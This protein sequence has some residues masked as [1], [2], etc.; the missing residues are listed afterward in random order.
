M[1]GQRKATQTDE[2]ARQMTGRLH[3]LPPTLTIHEAGEMLGISRRSAYRAAARGEIPTLR[4]GR[5]VLVPTPRLLALLGLMVDGALD[6][7]PPLAMA[8][9]AAPGSSGLAARIEDPSGRARE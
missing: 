3:E 9:A 5:R 8:A 7:Q 1:A 6:E 4:L 2:T